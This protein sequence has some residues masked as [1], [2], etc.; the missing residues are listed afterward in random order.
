LL[1]CLLDDEDYAM[2]VLH[3]L[4]LSL[5]HPFTT[6]EE[7]EARAQRMMMS[8]K[9]LDRVTLSFVAVEIAI[10]TFIHSFNPSTV[11]IIISGRSTRRGWKLRFVATNNH[12]KCNQHFNPFGIIIKGINCAAINEDIKT[13]SEFRL[14]NE[15]MEKPEV[16]FVPRHKFVMEIQKQQQRRG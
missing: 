15:I 1:A 11:T 14:R 2:K 6:Q 5:L 8:G 13:P 4:P 9:D 3:S 10:V 7:E 12:A 16:T